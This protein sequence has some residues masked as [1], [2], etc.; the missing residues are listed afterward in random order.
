MLSQLPVFRRTEATR[1]TLRVAEVERQ[2]WRVVPLP[3]GAE[4]PQWSAEEGAL[5]DTPADLSRQLLAL[6]FGACQDAEGRVVAAPTPTPLERPSGIGLEVTELDWA[7][8]PQ[9]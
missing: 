2:A 5:A 3:W 1:E 6:M 7:D 4:S 8:W 9:S